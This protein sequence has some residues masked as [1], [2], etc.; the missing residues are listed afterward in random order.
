MIFQPRHKPCPSC[1]KPN[2]PYRTVCKWCDKQFLADWRKGEKKIAPIPTGL[3]IDYL[4]ARA[5]VFKPEVA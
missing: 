2:D 4:A 1:G 3:M 5:R